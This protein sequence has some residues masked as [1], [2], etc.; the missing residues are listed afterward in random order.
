MG[1]FN[2]ID[3]PWI[4]CID[5]DGQRVGY[6]I[7]QTLL[8]AHNLREI[9]DDSP[10]VTVALHRLL[11][12]IL[13]RAYQGPQDM[14]YW[15]S[16]YQVRCFESDSALD[17]YFQVWYNRFYLFDDRHPFMQVA[18]LDLNEYGQ[19]G[20]IKRDKSDGLMRL[21]REAPDKGGPV[22]FDHRVGTERPEYELKE[23]ARMLLS[24]QCYSGTGVASGG[25]VGQQHIEP[26]PCLFAPCVEGLVLWI[27][28]ES[29]FQ[30]L[31]FNL[32]PRSHDGN[33]KPAWEDDA[34]MNAAINSWKA[35][36]S[37]TGPVQRFAS[38][39]RFVRVRDRQSMF[40]TNGLKTHGG[41]DDPMKAYSRSDEKDA[42]KPV[43]LQ[44]RRAAWRDVHTLF[45]LGSSIH[46][47]PE[48]LNHVARLVGDGT[49]RKTAQ[50]RANIAGLAT[51]RGK[52]LLWR[53]ERIPVP[54]DI[55]GSDDLT[56]RL[57]MLINEAEAVSGRLSSGLFQIPGKT[58]RREPVGRIQAIADLVLS[59][60]LEL[61]SEGVLRNTEGRAPNEAHNKAAL[62]LSENLDPC[63]AYWARLE[64]Y[65]FELLEDL[66]GDSDEANSDG[67]PDEQQSATNTWRKHVK[68]EAEQAL[69][70]SIR[71]LGTTSRA[72]Q[73]VARVRTSFTDDDLKPPER[74]ARGRRKARGGEKK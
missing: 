63:P 7:R 39:S 40:F 47:P 36:I 66:P 10:L 64:K 16:L 35:P 22:L 5:S 57:G 14:A 69:K 19:D 4:P 23:I 33:D 31:L 51:D 18:G 61:R 32:V 20:A 72:I 62:D 49:V 71:S 12:A 48:A 38:L 68:E 73:A 53:H 45:S 59:P 41:S 9:C 13:Y 65:F 58:I 46:K 54:L 1:E 60:S 15:K 70:V 42:Y 37:F 28:G 21:V 27:Q 55:L 2:L 52:A 34:V 67:K 24:A 30:T 17:N 3:E 26:T 44:E 29:L 11:L 43:K 25:M 74:A 6:G 50:P 56:E 8:N